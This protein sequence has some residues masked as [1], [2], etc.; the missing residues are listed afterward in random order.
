MPRNRR[1]LLKATGAS[2]AGLGTLTTLGTCG[3]TAYSD[4]YITTRDHFDDDGNLTSG[5]TAYDY[6]TSGNV[7]GV[8]TG[9][10]DDMTVFIHGWDMNSS[11]SE[12]EQA[13]LDKI[14]EANDELTAAGYRGTVVGM[15]WDNDKGG[16]CD[17]GWSVSEDIAQAN[18]YKLAQFLVDYKYNCPNGVVRLASHS[19]GAQVLFNTIRILDRSTWWNDHGHDLTTIHPFAAATDN[20]VPTKEDMDT[21]DALTR[22]VEWTYNY[23]NEDDSV[24]KWIYSV[25]EF[26]QALG[27]SGAESGNTTPTNYTDRDVTDRVGSDHSNYLPTIS[28]LIVS[29]MY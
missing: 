5:H 7:P 26:D 4:P 16:C 10:V 28:P 9:C 25:A 18:G 21:Y 20:E 3:T 24:L 1:T 2:L 12:A 17:F 22:Q 14:A 6:G 23:Y 27:K 15:T 11:H 13:A 8:D 19:L 29:D